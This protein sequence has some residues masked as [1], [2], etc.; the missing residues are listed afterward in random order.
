MKTMRNKVENQENK[1]EESI[2]YK[3]KRGNHGSIIIN[4]GVRNVN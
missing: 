3:E 4:K 2:L 1:R